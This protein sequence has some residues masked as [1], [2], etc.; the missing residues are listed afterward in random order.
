[1]TR[2][3]WR[4]PF[5]SLQCVLWSSFKRM[6]I[7]KKKLKIL[8]SLLWFFV[9]VSSLPPPPNKQTR[10]KWRGEKKT[11]PL[12]FA[13]SICSRIQ[14]PRQHKKNSFI[15]FFF[16]FFPPSPQPPPAPQLFFLKKRKRKKKQR[17]RQ[18]GSF[19]SFTRTKKKFLIKMGGKTDWKKSEHN[20]LSPLFRCRHLI[21]REAASWHGS[22]YSLFL[23]LFEKKKRKGREK[24]R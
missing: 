3:P 11:Y 9:I 24:N 4:F 22:K 15:F 18:S 23:L 14:P 20:S 1:M 21:L 6:Y 7:S 16:S 12:L 5:Y 2:I 19:Y 8:K 13:V 10:R 17:S